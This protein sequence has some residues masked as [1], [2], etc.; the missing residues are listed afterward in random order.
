MDSIGKAKEI[1]GM[2]RDGI[3]LLTVRDDKGI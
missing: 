3:C 2:T 1:T